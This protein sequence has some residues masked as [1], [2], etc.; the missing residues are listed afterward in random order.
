VFG[1]RKMD[2][3]QIYYDI[4]GKLIP[5]DEVEKMKE[6]S[7]CLGCFSGE[8]KSYTMFIDEIDA[9]ARYTE[10]LALADAL[11]QARNAG[12]VYVRVKTNVSKGCIT[13]GIT[14]KCNL[15]AYCLK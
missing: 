15:E 10:K 8:G 14:T 2:Q 9:C 5:T 1:E 13:K 11:N 4:S 3:K 6:S 7:I 12:A